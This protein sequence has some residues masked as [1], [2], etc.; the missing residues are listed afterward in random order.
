MAIDVATKQVASEVAATEEGRADVGAPTAEGDPAISVSAALRA[1]W[2]ILNSRGYLLVR[3]IGRGQYGT[4]HLIRRVGVGAQVVGSDA[5]DMVAKVVFLDNMKDKDRCLALQEVEL[6]R[7]LRHPNVVF[8]HESWLHGTKVEGDEGCADR[9]TDAARSPLATSSHGVL[10]TIMELCA[11]GD[12]RHWLEVRAKNQEHLSETAILGLFAQMLTGVRYIHSQRI[13][14]RDLK[15]G[16]MLL[17]ASHQIVKIGDFGISRVL[18]STVAVAMTTLGT[19]YYMSPEVCKGEPYREK[20]DIWSLGCVLYEMCVFRHAF[21]SQSLLGLVYCIVSERYEPVPERYSQGLSEFVAHLL[22]KNADERPSAAEALTF[23]VLKPLFD[24][25]EVLERTDLGSGSCPPPPPPV[26]QQAELGAFP[27]QPPPTPQSESVA[28]WLEESLDEMTSLEPSFSNETRPRPPESVPLPAPVIARTTSYSATCRPPP[29]PPPPGG[30]C[31]SGEIE[32]ETLRMGKTSGGCGFGCS[33]RSPPPLRRPVPPMPG[34][35]GVSIDGGDAAVARM[36]ATAPARWTDE[37]CD[38]KIPFARIRGGLTRRPRGQG[39]WVRAFALHDSTGRGLLKVAEFER[40]LQS[41]ALGLSQ[42]E[43]ASVSSTLTH[44]QTGYV[45]LTSFSEAA[46][47]TTSSRS[48]DTDEET[49]AA[50]LA[51]GLLGAAPRASMAAEVPTTIEAGGFVAAATK[52]AAAALEALL[53]TLPPL[54][55]ERLLLW[56]P[57]APD[58]EI[59][60]VAVEEWTRHASRP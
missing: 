35:Q 58:G 4:A 57:K 44:V 46:M 55:A 40:F 50:G 25:S 56:F 31:S 32:A 1:D 54:R 27:P 43:I 48:G 29:P 49:W 19:P 42:Q 24:G 16:N 8:Y 45:S 15:T 18:E 38:A 21:E 14:H 30:G 9:S 51:C 3:Q 60:W 47:P 26:Y 10:V 34:S 7:R 11:G 41:M 22:A 13:L 6:L 37:R 23:D 33:M 36:R 5:D 12:M 39:N 28:G 59:D 20:S 53:A 52:A 17:D 2:D